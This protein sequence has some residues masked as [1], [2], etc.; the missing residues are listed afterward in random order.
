MRLDTETADVSSVVAELKNGPMTVAVSAGN[1]CWRFYQGGI[2]TEEKA[3][4]ENCG[5]DQNHAVTLVAFTAAEEDGSDEEPT[6]EEKEICETIKKKCK[7]ATK[8]EK[9]AKQCGADRGDN[10]FRKNRKGVKKLRKCCKPKYDE[11]ETIEECTPARNL[12]AA[13]DA[14][15]YWTIQNSW[16]SNWGMSGFMMIEVT[17][18]LGVTGINQYMYWVTVM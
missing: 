16:G 1:K 6:C 12:Q 4:E 18:G 3:A 8:A 15:A 11:C 7:R 13:T 14:P 10:F 9:T 17:S 5:T 2:L